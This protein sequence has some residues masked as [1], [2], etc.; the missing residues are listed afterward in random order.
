MRNK[1]SILNLYCSDMKHL[2][3]ILL[4]YCLQFSKRDRTIPQMYRYRCNHKDSQSSRSQRMSPHTRP[5]HNHLRSVPGCRS[6][7]RDRIRGRRCPHTQYHNHYQRHPEL[8]V[9]IMSTITCLFVCNLPVGA[10]VVTAL[11]CFLARLTEEASVME[12]QTRT[13]NKRRAAFIFS[14]GG[15]QLPKIFKFG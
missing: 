4:K 12:A 3:E 1:T 15:F 7:L 5:R 14:S 13:P 11:T 10:A 8:K 6:V 9:Y 2:F